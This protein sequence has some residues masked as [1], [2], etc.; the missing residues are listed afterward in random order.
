MIET[1]INIHT[2]IMKKISKLSSINNISKSNVIKYLLKKIMHE[3]TNNFYLNRSIKYQVTDSKEKWHKFH[4]TLNVDEYEYFLD[5]RKFHKKSISALV[6]FALKK[7]Y[8]RIMKLKFTDNY[9]FKNYVII[10]EI[11][12][13]VITW[14]LF[15]GYPDKMEKILSI[16]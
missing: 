10:K 13:N 16:Q 7:Y 12:N 8:K 9:L 15:W 11:I 1:T 4:I 2:E 5:L 14:R 6:A 3:E